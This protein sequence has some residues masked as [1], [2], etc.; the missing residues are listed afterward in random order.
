[1]GDETT[2]ADIVRPIRDL[3]PVMDTFAMVEPVGLSELHMDP[4]NPVPHPGAGHMLGK[5]GA[6]AI[7]RFVDAAGSGVRLAARVVGDPPPRRRAPAAE[8]Q[9]RRPCHFRGRLPH[10]RRRDGPST[11]R[12]TG[13]TAWPSMPT[14]R[15]SS[16]TPNGRGYLNFTEHHTDPARFYAPHAYRRLREVKRAYDP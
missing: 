16:P 10:L 13:P 6:E 5:F 12:A 15:P 3:R 11:R 9:H 4:P 8:A 14:P 2:G 7:D 1:M